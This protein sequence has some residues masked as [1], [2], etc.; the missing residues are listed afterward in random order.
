M[1]QDF[2]EFTL[3]LINFWRK[4]GCL[5]GQS[6]DMPMGAGTFHP[7]TFFGSL[8]HKPW[9]C[10]YVQPCRRPVDGRYG[11]SPNRLQYYY[12]LQ[13]LMKPIPHNIMNIYLES[14]DFIG[15][16]KQDIQFL[17][18]DWKG[19]TLGAWGLGWEV[20]ANGQ[21][22]TQFTYFQQM[23]GLSLKHPSVEI[24]YGLE[25]LFLYTQ[26]LKNIYSIPYHKDVSY[27]DIY[28]QSEVEFSQYNF[29]E[30][31]REKLKT[32]FIFYQE[33]AI[34]LL[35]LNLIRPAYDYILKASHAFNILDARKVF[36]VQERQKSIAAIRNI[37][38]QCATAFKNSFLD[39]EEFKELEAIADLQKV[40]I[41]PKSQENSEIFLEI[42]VEEIPLEDILKLQDHIQKE[43]LQIKNQLEGMPPDFKIDSYITCRRIILWIRNAPIYGP[44]KKESFWGPLV[45]ITETQP[46]LLEKF[47]HK[48]EVSVSQISQAVKNGKEFL[49]LEKEYQPLPFSLWISEEWERIILSSPLTKTMIWDSDESKRFIRPIRWLLA[50]ENQQ[51]LPWKFLGLEAQKET[52][53]HRLMRKEPIHIESTKD[54]YPLLGD[55]KVTVSQKE[56][57]HKLKEELKVFQKKLGMFVEIPLQFFEDWAYTSEYPTLFMGEIK[58]AYSELP[59]DFMRCVLK[60]H[61]NYAYLDQGYYFGMINHP[62]VI[63]ER[64]AEETKEVVLARLEDAYFYYAKDVK[65]PLEEWRK[66]TTNQIFMEGIG[67]L[68]DKTES[69]E[70]YAK[71][72]FDQALK[73]N[74]LFAQEEHEQFQSLKK[75]VLVGCRY[76]KSDLLTGTVQEF[77]EE[78]QGVMVKHLILEQ[79]PELLKTPQSQLEEKDWKEVAKGI[80]EHYAPLGYDKEIPESLTGQIISL[81]DKTH[82]LILMIQKNQI[83]TSG[84][85]D[86][87]GIR[88]LVLGIIKI[89]INTKIPLTVSDLFE[90]SL[91]QNQWNWISQFIQTRLES[92]MPGGK[93]F[94]KNLRNPLC[95]TKLLYEESFKIKALDKESIQ[96]VYRRCHHFSKEILEDKNIVTETFTENK[97]KE[98][99]MEIKTFKEKLTNQNT[100]QDPEAW[101]Q[102]LIQFSHQIQD[103]LANTYIEDPIVGA[104]RK[105]M[106]K[107]SY[108]LIEQMMD[109][110]LWQ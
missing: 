12:Q 100:Q 56:R 110:S 72:I 92:L 59:K 53:G 46:E 30:A 107:N 21:E 26:K 81:I 35:L 57:E 51:L 11:L 41:W 44:T 36:S 69:L 60:T 89:L 19:P 10:V 87:A 4:Q 68:F 29:E 78:M 70:N 61:M 23:G 84:Q 14:L 88:R 33:E 73:Q 15:I 3:N 45:A 95:F 63:I 109:V 55:F 31:N 104:I 52:Y 34:R 76:S 47:A 6:Y 54:F 82:T 105:Q 58:G 49:F 98:F 32:D 102:S 83:K 9:N 74:A 80:G 39:Q 67:S 1:N 75:I 94:F 25:R 108:Q 40:S 66:K 24:T 77:P 16:K 90:G 64:V 28:H 17:E 18:D 93:A 79:I 43:I 7:H 50:I 5:W 85:G 96:N 2:S 91:D 106:L 99:F 71:M 65:V 97:D 13:V 8:D 20:R 22:I 48:H 38:T 27:K 37:A 86:S 103:Y 101:L 62:E 42:G